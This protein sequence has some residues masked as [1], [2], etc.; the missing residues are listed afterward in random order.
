MTLLRGREGIWENADP[1]GVIP[2]PG[3]V[4]VSTWYMEALNGG[5]A[6]RPT[7]KPPVS[8]QGAIFPQL[9]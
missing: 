7:R 3:R 2:Q 9:G 1:S 4:P 5:S 8:G 6:N